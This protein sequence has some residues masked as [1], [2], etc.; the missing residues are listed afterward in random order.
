MAEPGAIAP[1]RP[2]PKAILSA[3][4]AVWKGAALAAARTI[5]TTVAG[6]IKPLCLHPAARA[7]SFFPPERG[8]VGVGEKYKRKHP[9]SVTTPCHPLIPEDRKEPGPVCLIEILSE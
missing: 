1:V 5:S 2:S 8:S 7:A 9:D 3:F 6:G 4:G